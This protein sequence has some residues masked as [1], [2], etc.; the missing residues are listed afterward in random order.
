MSYI[1]DALKK[2]EQERQQQAPGEAD[3]NSL[4]GVGWVATSSETLSSTSAQ[5][6]ALLPG[7][8]L[9][10]LVAL[11]IVAGIW[12]MQGGD[13]PVLQSQVSESQPPIAE[14]LIKPV[15]EVQVSRTEALTPKTQA[16]T[17]ESQVVDT[18]KPVLVEAAE[19]SSFDEQP[20]DVN[21]VE[22][23]PNVTRSQRTLP[24]LSVLRTVPDL[25]ITGHI[26]SSMPEK[27]SVSMNGHE[28]SEGE[29]ISGNLYLKEITPDGIV[30]EV[31]GWNL[32]VKRNKGWQAIQ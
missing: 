12:F 7:L 10:L 2:S 1:L 27:R 9:G 3:T 20:A 4:V 19:D 11:L 6:S 22:S 26:Y 14:P 13:V 15:S 21:L 29:L 23:N 5:L 16:Q 30:V 18:T 31:D 25:I 8:L 28:W 32:P 17:P 24:P